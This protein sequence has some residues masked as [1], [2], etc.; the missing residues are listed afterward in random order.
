MYIYIYM[1]RNKIQMKARRSRKLKIIFYIYCKYL[2]FSIFSHFSTIVL[3][4]LTSH[5][6]FYIRIQKLS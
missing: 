6:N 1:Y 2:I 4:Y 5:V 3:N